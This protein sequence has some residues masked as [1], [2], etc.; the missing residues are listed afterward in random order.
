MSAVERVRGGTDTG[1][2]PPPVEIA[3]DEY[4]TLDVEDLAALD[5]AESEFL[6]AFAALSV[7]D[8]HAPGEPLCDTS[9]SCD[10][11]GSWSL[12]V[13]LSH[14]T[15]GF[16]VTGR[17]IH[18]MP[19]RASRQY[20][21][22]IAKVSFSG[23]NRQ[24]IAK[25]VTEGVR[26]EGH[27]FE[28]LHGRRAD[29]ESAFFLLVA[30]CGFPRLRCEEVLS[31]HIPWLPPNTEM[32]ASKYAARCDLMFSSTYVAALP[33]GSSEP[34]GTLSGAGTPGVRWREIPDEVCSETGAV[35]TDGCGFMNS[36]A[37][38][39]AVIA[40][41][42]GSN[43][44]FP[45][46]AAVQGRLGGYKGVWLHHPFLAEHRA[47][48]DLEMRRSMCKIARPDGVSPPHG[49]ASSW[50]VLR[51]SSGH[52]PAS[53]NMQVIAELLAW[54]VPPATLC[55]LQDAALDA[56]TQMVDGYVC[57]TFVPRNSTS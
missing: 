18:Q 51:C 1:A 6:E 44:A 42:T 39:A 49:A 12:V 41:G 33:S 36:A 53:L 17:R 15:A 20:L 11:G 52:G 50:E 34:G 46:A 45:S 3:C 2:A 32:A 40:L 35:M 29:S 19:N 21:G 24:Q 7:A 14:S 23:M 27:D 9:G 13:R 16:S 28:F 57:F 26:F 56:L 37:R 43:G 54:G 5:S 8:R 10:T 22:R 4:L 48:T 31:W 47:G 38:S 55:Y 30:G 25:V